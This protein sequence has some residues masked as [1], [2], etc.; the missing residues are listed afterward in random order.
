MRLKD[1]DI[2]GQEK[3]FK[4]ELEKFCGENPLFRDSRATTIPN[5]MQILTLL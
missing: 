3:H 1:E 5:D 2:N 4:T